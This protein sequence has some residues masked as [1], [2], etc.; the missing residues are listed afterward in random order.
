MT[1][2]RNAIVCSLAALGCLTFTGCSSGDDDTSSSTDAGKSGM[3]GMP[4]TAAPAAK[5]SEIYPM[6][7]PMSTNARCHAC[8]GAPP[9]DVANGN[10]GVGMTQD[11]AYAALVGKKSMSSRCMQATIVE[12]GK[13]DESLMLQKLSPNPPCGNRMPIGGT[14]FTDTQLEMIRSWIAAGAKND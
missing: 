5:W 14:P 2:R 3:A 1:A 13:P 12:Q 7:F 8:H 9:N 6:F 10:L 4:S 11:S